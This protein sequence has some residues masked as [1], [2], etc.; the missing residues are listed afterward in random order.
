[1]GTIADNLGFQSHRN[2]YQIIQCGVMLFA[3]ILLWSC[4]PDLSYD[5]RQSLSFATTIILCAF[6]VLVGVWIM[7]SLWK[8][9][10][11]YAA[12]KKEG[13]ARGFESVE[14]DNQHYDYNQPLNGKQYNADGTEYSDDTAVDAYALDDGT[15]H[16]TDED[17]LLQGYNQTYDQSYNPEPITLSFGSPTKSASGNASPVSNP[18]TQRSRW[19]TAGVAAGAA[20]AGAAAASGSSSSGSRSFRNT[21]KSSAARSVA[22]RNDSSSE[23][24]PNFEDIMKMPKSSSYG[25]PSTSDDVDASLMVA[26][27]MGATS[28][29]NATL[30]RVS[31]KMKGWSTSRGNPGSYGSKSS[32]SYLDDGSQS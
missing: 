17:K 31:K 15:G 13:R 20:V 5:T 28:R 9:I 26:D 29:A 18:A 6:M 14:L 22:E 8:T 3:L 16:Y 4:N 1:M 7:Y 24:V 32:G 10:V 2:W 12:V 19:S 11:Y 21:N 23:L 25:L 30:E 27:D